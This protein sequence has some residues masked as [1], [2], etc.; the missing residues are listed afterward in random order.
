[1]SPAGP[2]LS[3]VVPVFDEEENLP[4]LA[5]ELKEVL[6]TIARRSEVLFVDDGSRDRSF[7]VLKRLR[8]TFPEMRILRFRE[9]RGQSAAFAAGFRAAR[10]TFV[11]TLDADLQ[12]DPRDLPR[13]LEAL[14]GADAVAGVRRGRADSGWRR[15]QSRIANS[16][17]N[18]LTGDDILDTGCSLKGFRREVLARLPLFRNMHRFL[19]TL[20]KIAGGKVVQIEVAHRPRGAGRSKYGMLD[21]ALA[22][23]ADALAVRWMKRRRLDYEVVEEVG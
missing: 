22:G 13:I 10:G 6:G 23:L 16:V 4:A 3:I 5:A 19:P 9:N 17:R 18:L 12:N 1:V 21:R 2:E 11:V 7:E 20:V 14:E 15:V 8:A